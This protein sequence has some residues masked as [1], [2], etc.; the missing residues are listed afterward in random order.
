[1]ALTAIIVGACCSQKDSSDGK[2]TRKEM[3]KRVAEI[4]SILKER[5]TSCVYGSPEFMEEYAREGYRLRVELDSL[6][7]ELRIFKKCK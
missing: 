6:Q 2:M 5:E 3:R 1:M 7:N 4:K